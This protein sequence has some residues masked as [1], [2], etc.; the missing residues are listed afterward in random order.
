MS[1]SDESFSFPCFRRLYRYLG[2]TDAMVELT[3]LAAR[4]FLVAARDSGNMS[5]FL[6][7]E[8]AR[9]GI[10]VNLSEVDSLSSHLVR[11]YIVLVASAVERFLK[12][13]REE[14]SA[15]YRKVWT[16]DANKKDRLEVVFENLAGSKDNAEKRIGA[17]VISRFQYY[18]LL[19]N[20]IIH[21]QESNLRE[22]Q[23]KFDSIAPLSAA[24]VNLY[25]L[26]KA[27]NPPTSL[28][29][30]DFIFFSRL[31]KRVAEELCTMARPSPDHWKEYVDLRPFKKF[32]QDPKRMKNAI[33]G[34]I[35]TDYG[36]DTSTANWIA[37]NIMTH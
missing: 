7:K 22:P 32:Q 18:R 28:V 19:R 20:W 3:E 8:T 33:S 4:S 16:G 31:T 9:H 1:Q 29:F 15:L 30:D 37:E 24:N 27:P 11:T 2:E 14:H 25:N 35:R 5:E 12:D 6:A 13:L 23:E 34:K 10:H 17:D 21:E 36:L 26:L